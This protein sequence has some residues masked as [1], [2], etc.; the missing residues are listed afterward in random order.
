MATLGRATRLQEAES[1]LKRSNSYPASSLRFDLASVVLSLWFMIGLFLDGWA[2]NHV[3]ELETFFTPWHGV[4]Y[5]GYFVVAGLIGFT[6]LRNV[7]KGYRFTRALPQGYFLSLIGVVLFFFGGIGDLLWHEIF[8]IE[9]NAE[10]LFSPTHLLLASGALLFLSG[11]LR[12]AW[13]RKPKESTGW[14]DLFP[15]ILSLAMLFSFFTFFTQYSN[16]FGSPGV[17]TGAQPSGNFYFANVTAISYI[18]YP[19]AMMMGVLL[20]ALRRWQLP[21]GAVTLLFV[22]NAIAMVLMRFDFASQYWLIIIAAAVG[23]LFADVLAARWQPSVE[24]S[25]A[26]RLFAFAVPFVYFL[27]IFTALNLTEPRGLWWSIHMWLGVPVTAGAIG[28]GLSFL[29]APPALPAEA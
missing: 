1:D 2:H 8:G 11:P 18:L 7:M 29:I 27:L 23:G 12:A 15:A 19:A 22:T 17:L 9:Q 26:L 10:A 16:V 14:R 4:L 25:A 5:S 24:R 13:L 6:Q 20:F 28:V 3:A 21:P